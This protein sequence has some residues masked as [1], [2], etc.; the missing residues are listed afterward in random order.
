MPDGSFPFSRARAVLFWGAATI[1]ASPG[2]RS[3]RETLPRGD[4]DEP[5]AACDSCQA[6]RGAPCVAVT[7]TG[8]AMRDPDE[9][10]DPDDDDDDEVA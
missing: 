4:G 2:E 5:G 9:P 1:S 8:G 10:T 3:A 6:T 7:T